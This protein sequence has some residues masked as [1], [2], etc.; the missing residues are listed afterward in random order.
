MHRFFRVTTEVGNLI[1]AVLV[2]L[3]TARQPKDINEVADLLAGVFSGYDQSITVSP[4][5]HP[6]AED[7]FTF[8][9][10]YR[11]SVSRLTT[12]TI[13]ICGIKEV[14]ACRDV[15]V[16]ELERLFFVGRGLILVP[17]GTYCI[18][19]DTW[20]EASSN[21]GRFLQTGVGSSG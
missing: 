20:E 4:F 1:L 8:F 19:S 2:T 10:L 6:F 11:Q 12:Y 17:C 3:V 15:G 5:G 16:Q 7:G 18:S 9:V 14:S 13:A 21:L